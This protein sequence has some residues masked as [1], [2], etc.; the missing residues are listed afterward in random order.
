MEII[1][2]LT[3]NPTNCIPTKNSFEINH[4][5]F[6]YY[7]KFPQYWQINQVKNY[8]ILVSEIGNAFL[9]TTQLVLEGFIT[10]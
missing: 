9:R 1:I 10:I 5:I 4:F 3:L 7:D 8:H 6:A 2:S